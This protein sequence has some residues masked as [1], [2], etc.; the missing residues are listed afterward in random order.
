LTITKLVTIDWHLHLHR[1]LVGKHVARNVQGM[2][3]GEVGHFRKIG[4]RIDHIG[5]GRRAAEKIDVD[6]AQ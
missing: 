2:A 6:A 4:V 3:Q 1:G 5:A